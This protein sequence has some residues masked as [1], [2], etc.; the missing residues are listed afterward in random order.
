MTLRETAGVDPRRGGRSHAQRM[1]CGCAGWQG[2][3]RVVLCALRGRWRRRWSARLHRRSR[4]RPGEHSSQAQ[5][6][7]RHGHHLREP[8]RCLSWGGRERPLRLRSAPEQHGPL[9]RRAWPLGT[10]PGLQLP[11]EVHELHG[12]GR[13]SG[14][15]PRNS[16]RLL[17]A[18]QGRPWT[19]QST[20]C[21]QHGH[22][23]GHGYES[24]H[25]QTVSPLY[26]HHRELIP[27]PAGDSSTSNPDS[28]MTTDRSGAA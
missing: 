16:C 1:R 12:Q 21:G 24:D 28:S 8:T 26:A 17:V 27:A 2:R 22:L 19:A 9:R 14:R 3:I 20:S 23:V 13:A 5:Q 11:D 25:Q 6:P 7:R 4:Q 18:C 10:S 15:R